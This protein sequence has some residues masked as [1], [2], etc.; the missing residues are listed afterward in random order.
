ML[1]E[2]GDTLQAPYHKEHMFAEK[3]ERSVADELGV[4]WKEYSELTA[5]L[6]NLPLE[7]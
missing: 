5:K 7:K 3:I 4:D 6:D 1:D 2:P